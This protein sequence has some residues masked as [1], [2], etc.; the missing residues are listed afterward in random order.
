MG[1]LEESL[2]GGY[3]GLYGEVVD[4]DE[5]HLRDLADVVSINDP[6]FIHDPGHPRGFNFIPDVVIDLGANVGVFPGTPE[7]YSQ[8]L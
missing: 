4:R 7:N 5:Y 6:K 2:N 3:K 8:R 1:K